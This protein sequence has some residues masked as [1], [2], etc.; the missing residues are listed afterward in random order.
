MHPQIDRNVVNLDP[1]PDSYIYETYQK[2]SM[3]NQPLDARFTHIIAA[4]QNA[5]YS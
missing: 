4:Y 1:V 5:I 2:F 3:N